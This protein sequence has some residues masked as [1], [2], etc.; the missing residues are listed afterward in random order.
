MQRTRAFS[1]V[2]LSIVLVIIGL[3]VGGVLAGQA[4]MRASELR[5]V[6]TEY[7]R[8]NTAVQTFQNTYFGL[9]GDIKNATQFWGAQDP[10][11]A[12]CQT[13]A[14]TTALT[15]N[16][17]GNG[18]VEDGTYEMFRFWQQLSN[19]G[20]ISGQ[21]TGVNGGGLAD[22][23]VLTGAAINAPASKMSNAGWGFSY[24]LP[25]PFFTGDG[26]TYNMKYD[27]IFWF[28]SVQAERPQHNAMVPEDAWNID[29]KLDDGKPAT[30]IIIA[31][32]QQDPSW[33]GYTSGADPVWGMPNACTTSTS[34][35]DLTGNYNV[36]SP[37]IACAFMIRTQQ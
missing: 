4:M 21:F 28:G 33:A 17:N 35:D 16:G 5:A 27:N 11:P 18:Q 26:G 14:S 32:S 37:V 12:T 23:H 20:L 25:P 15:C 9:P 3:V 19:A 22:Q 30:G 29:T 10:T 24:L 13:T 1:L 6:T 7:Q 8:Y 34:K 2:E 36:A 31:R